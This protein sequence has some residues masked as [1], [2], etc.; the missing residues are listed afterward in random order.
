MQE[1]RFLSRKLIMKG[2]RYVQS[3]IF[4]GALFIN[5]LKKGKKKKEETIR[6]RS[7]RSKTRNPKYAQGLNFIN[8]FKKIN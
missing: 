7:Y 1:F 5:W 8:F 6:G 3:R 4:L 2:S